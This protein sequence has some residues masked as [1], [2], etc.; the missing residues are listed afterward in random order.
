M[1]SCDVWIGSLPFGEPRIRSNN[2]I[3]PAGTHRSSRTSASAFMSQD[4]VLFIFFGVRWNFLGSKRS[5]SP[6]FS[7]FFQPKLVKN[8]TCKGYRWIDGY[9]FLRIHYGCHQSWGV[10]TYGCLTLKVELMKLRRTFSSCFNRSFLQLD[11]NKSYTKNQS[12]WDPVG[13][14]SFFSWQRKRRSDVDGRTSILCQVF[15]E[16]PAS[17]NG[18]WNDMNL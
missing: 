8:R 9:E 15:V 17:F 5:K 10:V 11:T 12:V 4:W 7:E 6:K 13:F 2:P 16:H 1:R 3:F 18:T 14:S